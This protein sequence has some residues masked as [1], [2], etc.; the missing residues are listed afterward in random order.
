MNMSGSGMEVRQS[1]CWK[2]DFQCFSGEGKVEK[3]RKGKKKF[4]FV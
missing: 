1:F 4:N 2:K 3:R